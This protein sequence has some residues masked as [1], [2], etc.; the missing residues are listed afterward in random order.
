MQFTVEQKGDLPLKAIG[1]HLKFTAAAFLVQ[2][3]EDKAKI[4][5]LTIHPRLRLHQMLSEV[6]IK[7]RYPTPG[8]SDNI[9]QN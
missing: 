3:R 6:N 9:N 1:I 2:Q 4:T 5:S 7:V 8:P